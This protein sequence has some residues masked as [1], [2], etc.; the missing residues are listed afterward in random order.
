MKKGLTFS[1]KLLFSSLF[2]LVLLEAGL[3]LFPVIIPLPLLVYF[4]MFARAEIAHK[5]NLSNKWDVIYLERDDGGPELWVYRPLAMV[6]WP[7]KDNGAVEIRQMDEVG[8]CN[9]PENSY[10]LPQIDLIALGDSF[11]TCYAV[12]PLDTWS[13]QLGGLTGLSS[14]NLGRI[15]LGTHGEIQILKKFGLQKSPRIVILNVYEGNDLRD[16]LRYYQ[17]QQHQ[18]QPETE[19]PDLNQELTEAGLLGRYS[20]VFNLAFAFIKYSQEIFFNSTSPDASDSLPE[21]ASSNE[22]DFR[23]DLVFNETVIPFNASN[24]DQDE[25]YQARSVQNRTPGGEN[26]VKKVINEPLA[27]FVKLARQYGFVP[28]VSYTPSAYTAYAAKVAFK[29][30]TLTETMSGFSQ[31]Q[32]EFLKLQGQELGYKFIDLTQPLQMAAQ[33]GGPD[34]LLYFPDNRHLTPAGHATVAL[35]LRQ[36]LQELKLIPDDN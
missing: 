16:A 31:Y 5:L 30:P 12:N 2:T 32:R 26:L 7:V 11:T 1:A 6:R 15:G 9:P 3:H 29:D 22:V 18:E 19:S 35:A 21:L 25:V 28:V 36:A 8:F 24:E 4:N 13:S 27:V 14:Y 10:H 34:K 20:Y 23:Y 33:A 17:Y